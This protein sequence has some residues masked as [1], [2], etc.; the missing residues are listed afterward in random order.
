MEVHVHVLPMILPVHFSAPNAAVTE[1]DGVNTSSTSLSISWQPPPPLDQNG[2]IREYNVFYGLSTQ[3][4]SGYVNV[5]TAAQSKELVMLE[6][7]RIYTVYV[8]A[9]TVGPGPEASV[10]VS[11]D[12][13][14]K[15]S[16]VKKIF[17]CAVAP[18][19]VVRCC[20]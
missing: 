10:N 4:R 18:I 6:K 5:S 20:L 8:R 1:L 16:F 3:D 17:A 19:M 12:S 13:D 15:L 14:C 11:T 9:F 2:I 7:F